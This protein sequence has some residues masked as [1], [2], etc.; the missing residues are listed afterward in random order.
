[1]RSES[2]ADVNNQIFDNKLQEKIPFATYRVD[3]LSQ[4]KSSK[5]LKFAGLSFRCDS[6][7]NKTNTLFKIYYRNK[8]IFKYFATFLNWLDTYKNQQGCKYYEVVN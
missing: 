5:P 4:Y 6:K 8:Y 3:G 1:M 2:D 7:G